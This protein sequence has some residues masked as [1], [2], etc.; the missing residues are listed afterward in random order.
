MLA[1]PSEF[2]TI[3]IKQLTPVSVK[4]PAFELDKRPIA[5]FP[6]IIHAIAIWRKYI[7]NTE[8]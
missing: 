7:R 8:I 1:V 5:Y 6:C 2:W 4:Y 3:K